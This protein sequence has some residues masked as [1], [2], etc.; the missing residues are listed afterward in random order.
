MAPKLAA[1][2]DRITQNEKLFERIAAVYDA[3][4]TAGLTPEQKRLVWLDYTDFVRA[5][6]K[7]D[8]R[9]PRSAC[10]R[11]TS[12][13]PALYT[14]FSQN[15]LADEN[16]YVLFLDKETDL[17]GPARTPSARPRR[18]PPRRAGKKGKWAVLNT[19]SSVE[20]FLDLLG[21]ARPAREGLAHL[22]EPRR[23]RRRARQQHASSPRSW[24]SAPSGRS[25]WAIETHAHW[26]LE[27]TMAKTPGAGHGAHGGGL[28]A[29][30]GPR[31]RG[32]RRHAG[33]RRQGGRRDQ[34]RAR[35]TTATTPRR[36][37]RRSTTSTRT[38]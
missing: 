6:A 28:A 38:R 36:S 7:L 10:R 18:P 5:G 8:A 13:W 20:P 12:A 16:D 14:N 21:P 34:D 29:G 23:Q 24:R 30:G 25:C 31:P 27:N 15:V 22:R 35:G 19:R 37:A 4:E 2:R 26:R 32:G 9:R 17:A 3:R 33:D 1:F 11:S